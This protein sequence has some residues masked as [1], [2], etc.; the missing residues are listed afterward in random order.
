V[1]LL[2]GFVHRAELDQGLAM[3]RRLRTRM[4]TA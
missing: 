3:M 4:G 2:T 1:L